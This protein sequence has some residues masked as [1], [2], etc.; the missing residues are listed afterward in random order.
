MTTE[1]LVA[2]MEALDVETEA[3]DAWGIVGPGY[4][5]SVD[6]ETFIWF[7]HAPW[8]DGKQLPRM[9]MVSDGQEIGLI[10]YGPDGCIV[11]T[12]E[13]RNLYKNGKQYIKLVRAMQSSKTTE[14]F[15]GPYRKHL[16]EAVRVLYKIEKSQLGANT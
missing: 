9:T 7:L 6:L 14:R 4:V 15:S 10:L 1:E 16:A 8:P 12:G 11:S 13:T 2:N 5:H 3:N